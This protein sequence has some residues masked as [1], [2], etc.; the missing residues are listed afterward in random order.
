M[1]TSSLANILIL[2]HERDLHAQ[3]VKAQIERDGHTASIFNFGEASQGLPATIAIGESGERQS[4]ATDAGWRGTTGIDGVWLRRPLSPAVDLSCFHVDDQT[5]LQAD[6][7]IYYDWMMMAV[8][9]EAVWVN[10]YGPHI[11]ASN[12]LL[13]YRAAAALGIAFPETLISS[14]PAAVR[15]FIGTETV[16]SKPL[17]RLPMARLRRGSEPISTSMLPDDHLLK[18]QPLFLQRRHP[19]VAEFRVHVLDDDVISVRLVPKGKPPQRDDWNSERRYFSA[20]VERLPGDLESKCV[21]LTRTLGLTFCCID[22]I[23]NS[24]GQLLFLEANQM[25]QF[26]WIEEMN[27]TIHIVAAFSHLLCAKASERS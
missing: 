18:L 3:A 23:E 12:K 10:S 6:I 9:P 15:A 24:Q 5:N 13:Q 17:S 8:A 19:K 1:E 20:T 26:L 11:R 4:L 22:F 16:L 27:P 7:S 2:S 21:Q 25:G 14:C